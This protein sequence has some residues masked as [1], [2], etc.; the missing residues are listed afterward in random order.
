MDN[1]SLLLA[2]ELE[3]SRSCYPIA[4]HLVETFVSHTLTQLIPQ[5]PII[6]PSPS[7]PVHSASRPASVSADSS[8]QQ[9]LCLLLLGSDGWERDTRYDSSKHHGPV[10]LPLSTAGNFF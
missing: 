9:S 6:V 7:V 3:E 4:Y 8:Q 5:H 2:L 1:G 10:N